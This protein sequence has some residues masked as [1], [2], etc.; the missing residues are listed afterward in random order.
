[1]GI[2]QR[3]FKKIVNDNARLEAVNIT[4]SNNI[5]TAWNGE[6]WENDIYRSGVDAIA[7]HCAKLQGAHAYRYGSTLQTEYD[8]K[9]N[10]LLQ[11]QPNFLMSSYDFL[12]KLT[13]Q[14][15]LYNNAFAYLDRDKRGTIQAIY[16]VNYATVDFLQDESGEIYLHFFFR[17]GNE[18]TLPYRDIVHLRRNFNTND[19]IGDNNSAI[20]AGLQLAETENAGIISSIQNGANIRG[21]LKFTTKLTP[22]TKEKEKNNFLTSFLD[23]ANNGGVIVTD[24][25]QEYTP[26]ESKPATINADQLKLTKEKIYNYLGI[27]EK[28][29]NSTYD[30]NEFSAFLESVVEPF[31][32]QLSLAFTIKAFNERERAYGNEIIF[33][34]NR[35]IYSSNETKLKI[36]KELT[37]Y[38]LLTINEAREILNLSAVPDGDRRLQ[39]LNVIDANKAN[40]YQLS[41]KITTETTTETT[42]GAEA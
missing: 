27:S 24:S 3:I 29:V 2:F 22:E 34:S 25:A 37:P 36:I 1:M 5:L 38:G 30:E 9:L 32:L 18:S 23:M 31:G 7:R 40:E 42:E 26:I 28:I 8:R 11:I 39:T 21:I 14:L 15:Y 4:T 17:N 6:A 20:T 10:R 19:I 13:T 16:P 41:D 12:Y 35:L 33:N